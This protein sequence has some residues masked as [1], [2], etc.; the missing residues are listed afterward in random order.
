MTIYKQSWSVSEP[1]QNSEAKQTA[2]AV[3]QAPTRNPPFVVSGLNSLR[4]CVTIAS[5]EATL[6]PTLW[7]LH[8]L[9]H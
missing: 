4:Y 6:A 2:H 5:K 1:T 8:E 7:T 3:V 9:I